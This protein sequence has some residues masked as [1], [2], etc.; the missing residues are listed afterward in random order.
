M[1]RVEWTVSGMAELLTQYNGT[2]DFVHLSN[3]LDWLPSDDAKVMLARASN[4]LRPGGFTLIRQLNSNLDIPSLG[5]GFEWRAD[6]AEMLHSRDRSFFY[7]NLH[8]GMKR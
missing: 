2:V 7:R 4:A 3:I 5:T 8:V 1:P 6:L